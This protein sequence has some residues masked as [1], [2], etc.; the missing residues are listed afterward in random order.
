MEGDGRLLANTEGERA[1]VL[2]AGTE[3]VGRLHA[4]TEIG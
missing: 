3:E 1:Q 2:Q 4:M